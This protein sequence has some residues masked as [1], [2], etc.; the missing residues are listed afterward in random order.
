LNSGEK[1]KKKNERES[2][3]SKY[4]TSVQVDDI[5]ICT[6]ALNNGG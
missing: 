5:M 6:E 4:I 1:G 2:T 3:I